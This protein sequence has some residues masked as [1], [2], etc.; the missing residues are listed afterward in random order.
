MNTTKKRETAKEKRERELLVIVASETE[1]WAR[2]AESY[3]V[4]FANVLFRYM[5][6]QQAAFNVKQIDSFTYEFSRN[7]YQYDDV[8]L[9]V[10][11][12]A[13]FTWEYENKVKLVER[14]LAD[15]DSE[16]SEQARQSWVRTNALSKLTAEE[17][18][19]LNV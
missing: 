14:M 1:S 5:V 11:P 3:P 9:S 15:Y 17:R 19:L 12:P 16:M 4:R 6:L 7:D 2:F 8:M 18:E 13:E 10:A